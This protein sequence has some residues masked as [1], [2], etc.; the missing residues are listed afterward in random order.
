MVGLK[1]RASTS[2]RLP[3]EALDAAHLDATARL[4][5]AARAK[6]RRDLLRLHGEGR[7]DV[8]LMEDELPAATERALQEAL[9]MPVFE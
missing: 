3:L 6:Q 5:V 9:E 2:A 8:D 4:H 1:P 7:E